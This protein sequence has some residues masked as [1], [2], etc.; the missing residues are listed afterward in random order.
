M[1]ADQRLQFIIPNKTPIVQLECST[2]FQKL[3]DKEKKYAHYLSQAGWAGGLICLLQT[4]PEAPLIFSL[5]LKL[6]K[7]ESIE[8]LQKKAL[9]KVAGLSAEEFQALLMYCSAFL[10]NF[11]NYKSFGDTKFV[12][13]ISQEKLEGIVMCSKAH[14][15]DPS[16][17]DELW[18]LVKVQIFSL[19][20]KV[21]QLG[22]AEK[23]L[24]T[25]FSSNCTE[26]DAEIAKTFMN[27]KKIQAYN[28]RLFKTAENG[29]TTY[30]IRLASS[31]LGDAQKD[32]NL[33]K[34]E[35][36]NVT[37]VVSR[38]DYAPLMAQ[39]V[40]NLKKAKEF[41][42]NTNE[43]KMLEG[44]I[45][46]FSSGSVEEHMEGSRYWIRDTGPIVEGYIGFIESYRDPFGVRGEWEGFVAIVNKEMS[47]KFGSLV[48]N[49]ESFLP[50]LPWPKEYEKD[51]FLRPDF[52]SL[53]VLSFASSGIP[54]G[55]NIPN[56]DAIRQNEGFKNVSLGNVLAGH[57]TDQVVTFLEKSDMVS[58][59]YLPGETWD[60]KFP[61]IS[62]SYEEC[63]AECVGIYLCTSREILKIFG[64]E[65]QAASDILYINWLNMVRAGVLGL[66]FYTPKT[67]S[68]RQAHM[69]ARFVILRVLMEAGQGLVTIERLTGEDGKPDAVVKLDKE[70]IETVGKEAIGNFLRKL[71]VYKSVA[72]Y[73]TAKELYDKYSAVN[74]DSPEKFLSLRSIVLARKQPR[75]MFVQ[76]NTSISDDGDVT[77]TDYEASTAGMIQSYVERYSGTDYGE[78]LHK[79][80]KKDSAHFN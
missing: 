7:A 74:D 6:F 9:E 17:V 57:S 23:G 31:E 16:G 40:D 68:W 19:D 76:V 21:Q 45:N 2:A 5:V 27:E 26:A 44:Y 15:V 58:S 65:G 14:S 71:Q 8:D 73:K 3:S 75:R 48:E 50:L 55:I 49:A 28:T 72:D 39:V 37:F 33:G 47:A 25:Y 70:K 67:N 54:A 59:W 13:D 60:S 36:D 22:L 79:L 66:E 38:G 80:W 1:A 43:E 53:E 11:G 78:I 42:A 51:T 35:H 63:R 41:A 32:L 61:V 69:Q 30:E 29:K 20:A 56:Y 64:H 77:M 4:S 18:N 62:S 24:T 12:P 10:S 46:S 34:H 52:T